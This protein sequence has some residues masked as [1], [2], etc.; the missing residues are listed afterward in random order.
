MVPNQLYGS[1][2]SLVNTFHLNLI[3]FDALACRFPLQMLAAKF[4]FDIG[5]NLPRL[6]LLLHSIQLQLVRDQTHRL[7]SPSDGEK[8]DASG[9]LIIA[10]NAITSH[11][12]ALVFFYALAHGVSKKAPTF[13]A[14]KSLHI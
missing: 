6:L 7:I 8:F 12:L 2:L 3:D 5:H 11:I 10:L 9:F 1:I 4:N 14:K 13:L